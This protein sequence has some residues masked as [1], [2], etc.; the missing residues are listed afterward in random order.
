MAG[1]H[2]LLRRVLAEEDLGRAPA[3]VLA[4]LRSWTLAGGQ[5][6]VLVDTAGDRPQ[7]P[8]WPGDA[9]AVGLGRID[10]WDPAE[11]PRRSDE[12]AQAWIE[13]ALVFGQASATPMSAENAEST[14]PVV[15]GLSTPVRGLV[16]LMLLF[17]VL[18]GPVN[19][20]VLSWLKRRMWLLWTVP[21]GSALF[22]GAVVAYAFFSEGIA[23][24]AR[25]QVVT[26]L[27]QTT[28]E[29][30][31]IGMR[32]YYAPLTPGDGLRFSMTTRVVPQTENG[33]WNDAGRARTVDQTSRQHL[34]RGW[35]SARVPAHLHLTVVEER[36]ERVDVEEL[37]G[38]GVAVT[39]GLGVDLGG[40]ALLTPD[41]R[42]F[43]TGPLA[44]G[45]RAEL[46][47]GEVSAAPLGAWSD[48]LRRSGWNVLATPGSENTILEPGTYEAT[49]SA[50]AFLEDGID[51]IAEHRVDAS[52]LARYAPA[53]ASQP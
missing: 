51:G 17:A 6:V 36:R 25:T 24:K 38:G 21:L 22:S 23:P 32:G 9:S 33:G 34:D 52:I 1:L 27:D 29:A 45:A 48:Q 47:P 11:E 14:F 7:P 42:G 10:W 13:E 40:V 20:L 35:V 16:L 41:G 5:L 30:V 39:N 53:E 28:R 37:P 31:T 26:Y 15:E 8:G 3:A 4:A 44:A 43:R 18:I 2:R 46:G 50:S 49:L 19:I 12:A